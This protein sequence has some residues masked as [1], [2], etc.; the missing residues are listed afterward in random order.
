MSVILNQSFWKRPFFE[1][2]SVLPTPTLS[3]GG[4]RGGEVR[5]A[6]SADDQKI[7]FEK[8]ASAADKS[9]ASEAEN[10][11]ETASEAAEDDASAPAK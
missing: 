8:L 2:I 9:E 4:S 3:Y 5:V 10:A 1:N 11:A 6:W 7:T